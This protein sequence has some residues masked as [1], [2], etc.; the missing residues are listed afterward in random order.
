MYKVQPIY[1][2]F[3]TLYTHV[4]MLIVIPHTLCRDGL[5]IKVLQVKNYIYLVKVYT[6]EVHTS[7]FPIRRSVVIY[8]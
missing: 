3:Y 5:I 6:N 8:E 7:F 1:A 2:W 4:S